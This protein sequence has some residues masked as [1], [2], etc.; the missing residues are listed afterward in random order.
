M[1]AA[2]ILVPVSITAAMVGAGTSIA[3]PDTTVGEVAWVSAGTYA[4]DDQRTYEG[5]IYS[6]V[7][8][9]TG[10]TKLPP[11][12]QTNWLRYGPTNRMAAFDDYTTTPAVGTT[13]LTLVLLPGFFNGIRLDGLVGSSISLTLKDAPGGAVVWSF[14]GDLWE[15]ALGFY[16]L[17]YQ[18]LLQLKT[19]SFDGLP[20]HPNPELTITITGA[21]GA[22][23]KVGSVMLGDWRILIGDSSFGGVSY[24]ANSSRKSYTHWEEKT[25]G[26]Y[27]IIRRP[28]R[29]DVQCQAQFDAAQAMYADA[30]LGEVIDRLVAFEASDLPRYGYLN[31]VGFV[32]GSIT[33]ETYSTSRIDL[34]IKGSI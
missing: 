21:T 3:E 28:S 24:G 26:T 22:D 11:N 10:I 17:L 32:S 7:K 18:P 5:S 19:L 25:D 13:S 34:Q 23:V 15:Q 33:A 6:C 1:T 9:H 27:S 4:L 20:L 14:S 29:R 12:D 8:A 31:T 16:E 30:L 2:R